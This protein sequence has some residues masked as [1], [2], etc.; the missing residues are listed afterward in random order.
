[1]GTVDLGKISFTQKGTYDNSTSYAPKDV[2]QH[3]DQNETSSFV[4]ISS[5][6]TGQVPQT[7]GT[8]NSSHWQI[9]AKGSSVASANQGTY[10]ASTTYS[11]GA[12]V[13][14]TDSGVLSTFLYIN[15]TPA[16]GQTPSTGGTVNSSH[17]QLIAKGTASIAL[18][19]KSTIVT[20]STVTVAANEGHWI[21]TTSNACT[22]T[23][24]SSASVGDTIEL[25]DYARK[26]DTNKVTINI[27]GL[28]WQ[29]GTINPIYDVKGQAVRA[30]YSGATKGWIPT[31]D[32]DVTDETIL[33]VG[34]LVIAGG[35]GGGAGDGG[36]G[37]AGGYRHSHNNEASGGGA[38]SENQITL[39]SGVTYNVTIGGGGAGESDLDGS[40]SPGSTG[41]DSSLVGGSVSITSN[42]GGGGGDSDTQQAGKSGGSGGGS[43]GNAAGGSGTA[44]QGFNGGAGGRGGGGG[45]GEA[46]NTDGSNQGGD[47]VASTITG[48]SV[49]RAGGGA[50]AG[51]STVGGDG[52]GGNG[53]Q[54]PSV[55]AGSGTA[56]TGGGGGGSDNRASGTGGSGLVI[57]RISASEYSGTTSGSPT[58][59]D[60]GTFKV[61]KFTGS[62]SYTH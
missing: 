31:S 15:T 8:I 41:S 57:L 20:G 28:K 39:V 2:V 43:A 24:P 5:T 50:G 4:K 45:A 23:F 30:V 6:A 48:S 19:W 34:H 29:G 36:G 58:V 44:N 11:K 10:D 53:G 52:G 26:W 33:P 9:F 21:D 18:D 32:D 55:N 61:I 60:D 12:V 46:G 37:G 51:S 56:N 47:G 22:V 40:K 35:G 7:N 16:S 13:Q 62:G 54:G 27:N 49:T 1:M 42:G 17:W 14:F 25:V 38:S 59:T 3:T